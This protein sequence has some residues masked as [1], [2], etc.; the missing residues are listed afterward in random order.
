M[1]LCSARARGIGS[2]PVVLA[3]TE[4]GIARSSLRNCEL[5]RFVGLA[6]GVWRLGGFRVSVAS[7]LIF[8]DF[9]FFF[10]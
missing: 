4:A 5:L 2:R 8:F 6:F 10:V 1:L 3:G 7:F 9:D